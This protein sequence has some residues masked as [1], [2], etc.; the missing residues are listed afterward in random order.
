[1]KERWNG[2]NHAISQKRL[3]LSGGKV[4]SPG[5]KLVRATLILE[6]TSILGLLPEGA[7]IPDN[8]DLLDVSGCTVAPGFIDTHVH[9]GGG[10]NFM[11][12]T[13]EALSAISRYMV[14]GGVTACLATTTS[15]SLTDLTLALENA[16]RAKQSPPPGQVEVVG[17]HLEGPFVN[18]Q[19]RG[20]HDEQ[21]VRQATPSELEAIWGASGSTLRVVTLAPEQPGGME[22]VRFLAKRGVQ[23]SMGHTGA[24][25]DEARMA[26]M[27]GVRRGTH[28][29]NAMPPI[30]HREPGP[31]TALLGDSSAFLELIV[32][33]YH[34]NPVVIDMTLRLAGPERVVLITD[35]TDVAGQGEGT[36][37]R[38]EGTEVVIKDGQ[39]RTPSGS[40]AGS[41]LSMDHAVRNLVKF[42]VPLHNALRMATE[43]PARSIGVFDRK[44]SL[45]PGKDADVVVLGNDLSTTMTI[46]RGEIAYERERHTAEFRTDSES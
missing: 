33:G 9:G 18:P 14:R 11:T 13:Q 44:G 12:G 27:N 39:S 19:F 4:L 26:L 22:A 8:T 46:V 31:L 6:G 43:T 15:A 2:M 5:G 42:G 40:L 30:H 10:H 16:A 35:C 32:D 7:E 28:V 1:M 3:A 36:F 21:H 25:Y 24:T 17:V 41:I 45:S 34:V 20:V 29:F 38:W 23:V 37:T